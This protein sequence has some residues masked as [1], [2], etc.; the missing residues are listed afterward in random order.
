VPRL[1]EGTT[2]HERPSSPATASSSSRISSWP[3]SS[4]HSSPYGM[5]PRKE[6]ADAAR[7]LLALPS[8][9]S[10]HKLLLAND[11]AVRSRPAWACRRIRLHVSRDLGDRQGGFVRPPHRSGQ[12]LRETRAGEPGPALCADRCS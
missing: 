5:A 10:D 7:A 11:R 8:V 2:G 3:N 6:L 4:T 1:D 9:A 12:E